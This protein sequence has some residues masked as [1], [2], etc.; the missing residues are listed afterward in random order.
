MSALETPLLRQEHTTP[1][2]RRNERGNTSS[3]GTWSVHD[4]VDGGKLTA[5]NSNTDEWGRAEM[6]KG[7]FHFKIPRK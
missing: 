1:R 2:E 5:V 7:L 6:G 3:R 4:C